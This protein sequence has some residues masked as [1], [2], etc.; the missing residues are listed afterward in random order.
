M[1]LF[2]SKLSIVL[3]MIL[4]AAKTNAQK[5]TKDSTGFAGDNFSLQ[6]AIE[7]FKKASS[8]EEFEKL[9]NT[10]DKSVNNLDLNKDGKIDYVKV[11]EKTERGVHAFILQVPV[12]QRENLLNLL[13]FLSICFRSQ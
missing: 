12:S 1:K 7:M 4:L 13:S 6:G 3:T 10:K 5:T 11:I 9:I 2:I 8:P